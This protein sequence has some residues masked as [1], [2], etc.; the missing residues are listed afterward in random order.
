MASVTEIFSVESISR[1]LYQLV[2]EP[3]SGKEGETEQE[4][5]TN[6]VF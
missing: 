2:S 6:L 3:W 4:T 1:Y 5:T